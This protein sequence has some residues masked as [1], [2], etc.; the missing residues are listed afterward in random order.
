M[1]VT[2]LIVILVN[3]GNIGNLLMYIII[4]KMTEDRIQ[5]IDYK[6]LFHKELSGSL[7][8]EILSPKS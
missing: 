8:S 1:V 2:G 6:F 5:T 4:R 7:K 3:M